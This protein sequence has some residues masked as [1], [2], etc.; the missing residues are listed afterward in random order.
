[1]TRYELAAAAFLILLSLGVARASADVVELKNGQRVEGTFKGGDDSAVK[2]EIGGQ[3]ITFKPDQV[4]AMYFGAAPT[5]S[6]AGISPRDEALK[7]LKA[8]QSVTTGGT[9]Y[10]DYAPRVSD[11]KIIVDRYLSAV[12]EA[13][14][15]PAIATAM[16]FYVLA[17]SAWSAKVSR[18]NYEA[19][20]GNPLIERC[21]PIKQLAERPDSRSSAASRG[22]AIVI[23]GDVSMIWSCA[24]DQIA[25]VEKLMAGDKR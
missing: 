12:S 17:G 10:R 9:N 15:R 5:A 13:P 19:V 1:M 7:A 6:P 4:R 23:L 18:S 16:G 14:E 11:A 21:G 24:S 25:E 22:I 20:G 8:L 2:I 3:V